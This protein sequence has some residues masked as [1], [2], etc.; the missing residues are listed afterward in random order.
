[1]TDVEISEVETRIVSWRSQAAAIQS[2]ATEAHDVHAV[3]TRQLV[4]V[5][6][7]AGGIY[8][9]IDRVTALIDQGTATDDAASEKLSRTLTSLQL[10]L[11]EITEQ[12][13]SMYSVASENVG[14]A[15]SPRM[16]LP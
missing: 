8:R 6:E 10:V 3:R 2:W 15:S 5:E 9:E 11:M 4:K 13:T 16:K 12:G 1:M 14:A 7:I